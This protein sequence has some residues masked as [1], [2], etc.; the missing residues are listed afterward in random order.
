MHNNDNLEFQ[1]YDWLESHDVKQN[2]NSD[3]YDE[4]D[5]TR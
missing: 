3:C 1:L 5:Y 4:E 2:E